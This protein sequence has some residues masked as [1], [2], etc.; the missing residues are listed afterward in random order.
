MLQTNVTSIFLNANSDSGGPGGAWELAVLNKLPSDVC[1]AGPGT[2]LSNKA[3]ELQY[4][5]SLF[6]GIVVNIWWD[7]DLVSDLFSKYENDTSL[8]LW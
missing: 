3:R 1:N 5:S 6:M 7:R 8:I 4:S 2:P